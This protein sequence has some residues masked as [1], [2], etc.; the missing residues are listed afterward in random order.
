[1]YQVLINIAI[2]VAVAGRH[3]VYSTRHGLVN[4]GPFSEGLSGLRID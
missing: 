2:L 4:E 3:K 1:M